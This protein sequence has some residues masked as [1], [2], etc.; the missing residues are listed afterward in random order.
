[1]W[2]LADELTL[3][4]GVMRGLLAAPIAEDEEAAR[5]LMELGRG[6]VGETAALNQVALVVPL[7]CDGQEF[8]PRPTVYAAPAREAER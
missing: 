2:G 6:M 5:E 4:I 3:S 1:V 7:R 8:F